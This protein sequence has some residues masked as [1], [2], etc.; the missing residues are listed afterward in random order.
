MENSEK[1]WF[2]TGASTGFGREI[3]KQL[4]SQGKKVAAT[5][6]DPSKLASLV[7]GHE[8]RALALKLDVTSRSQAEAAVAQTLQHFGRI[9]VLINNAGY[10][11]TGA[12]EEGDEAE[13]REMFDTNFF[14]AARMIHLVL[15]AMRKQ[16]SGLIINISS[17]AGLVGFPGLGYYSATKFALEG[18]SE[19]LRGEVHPL[20]IQV[21]AVEPSG[22]RTDFAGRSI[23]DTKR[24]IQDYTH[25]ASKTKQ[26]IHDYHGKQAGD[27]VRAAEA[28][29]KAAESKNPPHHLI[30]G[31]DAFRKSSQKTEAFMRLIQEQKEIALAA[32]FPK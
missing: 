28:I 17:I 11:Y 9:D 2:L 13:V 22:F 14:G 3:V 32:D 31:E 26:M 16:R 15:P 29:I 21:M 5:A 18:L 1:V 24:E 23:I 19:S 10:G 20:G 27:P 4:L 12:I 25:S 30:L 6:R 7:K 8:G